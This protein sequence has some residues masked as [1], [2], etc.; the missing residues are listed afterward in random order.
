VSDDK[1]RISLTDFMEFSMRSG[2]P[3]LTKVAE[4]KNRLA[5][6]PT[7]D[8]WKKLRDRICELHEAGD[9]DIQELKRFAESYPYAKKVR[10]YLSAVKGYSR[11]MRGK[12]TSWFVPPT[13]F[14]SPSR[15]QV[16]INPEVGLVTGGQRLVIKFYFKAE[17]LSKAKIDMMTY[18][19][20]HQ[21]QAA[22]PEASFAVLDMPKGRLHLASEE[23]D[24]APLLVGEAA[25]FVAMWDGLAASRSDAA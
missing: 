15:L 22:E 16:R 6:D 10:N 12:T 9:F 1:I 5:Y 4:I 18:L 21:L 20:R 13:G 23:R 24:L 8:Y 2:T 17:R 25:A 14:W 3:R 7:T 19:L 11:Y